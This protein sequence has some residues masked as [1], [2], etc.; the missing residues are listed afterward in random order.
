[1]FLVGLFFVFRTTVNFLVLHTG[2][3][4]LPPVPLL[5]VPLRS[6]R[7][8]S[9]CPPARSRRHRNRGKKCAR[10]R[11][12]RTAPEGPFSEQITRNPWLVVFFHEISQNSL[13]PVCPRRGRVS[14]STVIQ[15]VEVRE[16]AFLRAAYRYQPDQHYRRSVGSGLL[17]NVEKC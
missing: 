4:P 7:P 16:H 17:D 3:P 14:I 13:P 1:M 11:I 2:V 10:R 5:S 6:T 8:S 12:R 15:T 9:A